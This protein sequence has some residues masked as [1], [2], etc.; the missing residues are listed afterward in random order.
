[1]CYHGQLPFV[2]CSPTASFNHILPNLLFDA[3]LALGDLSFSEK[4][5]TAMMSHDVTSYHFLFL[6]II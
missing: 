1:L 2:V 4:T 6:Y 5:F 3:F